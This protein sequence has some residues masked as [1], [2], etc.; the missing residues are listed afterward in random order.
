M[1]SPSSLAN[2]PSSS[3]G[4]AVSLGLPQQHGRNMASKKK[5]TLPVNK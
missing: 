5:M 4:V 1:G 2:R 3:A